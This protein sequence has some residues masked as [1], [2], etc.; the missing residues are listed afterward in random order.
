MLHA[1]NRAGD[2]V[3]PRN[4][5]FLDQKI[6]PKLRVKKNVIG[7]GG[8]PTGMIRC[9]IIGCCDEKYLPKIDSRDRTEIENGP[10]I[11]TGCET[12]SKRN[13][14][15]VHACKACEVRRLERGITFDVAYKFMDLEIVMVS[16]FSG[17]FSSGASTT[18]DRHYGTRS[19]AYAH[20]VVTDDHAAMR[21]LKTAHAPHAERNTTADF[22]FRKFSAAYK[23]WVGA[24]NYLSAYYDTRFV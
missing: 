23:F 9:P 10:G 8:C 2:M 13:T 16:L 11:K 12:G 3:F 19:G 22:S 4:V 6:H 1:S 7:T 24:E 21:D 14:F 18:A 20:R 17:K 5:D 15:Y